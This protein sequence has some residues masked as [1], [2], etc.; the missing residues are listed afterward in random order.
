VSEQHLP[1]IRLTCYI[2]QGYSVAAERF[3]SRPRDSV[4]E[5]DVMI[6]PTLVLRNGH[7]ADLN[8]GENILAKGYRTCPID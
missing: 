3:L 2:N 4:F 5:G 7:I 1:W 6:N 8:V